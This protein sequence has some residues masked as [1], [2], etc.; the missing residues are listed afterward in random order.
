[1]FQ[2]HWFDDGAL[3][4]Q[5]VVG[6]PVVGLVAEKSVA[7]DTG[8]CGT[9]GK[10][11]NNCGHDEV[12]DYVDLFLCSSLVSSLAVIVPLHDHR[13]L[14]HHHQLHHHHR[15]H[16]HLARSISS[17]TC[18]FCMVGRCWGQNLSPCTSICHQSLVR[19][20]NVVVFWLCDSS[21]RFE[22]QYGLQLS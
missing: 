16:F 11:K 8:G 4:G 19:E 17:F 1:M 15:L 3:L 5:L 7:W 18:P 6:W 14:H 10:M 20:N 13:W 12:R 2:T 22:L 9:I 21:K